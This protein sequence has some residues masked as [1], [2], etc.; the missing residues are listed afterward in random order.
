M[1]PAGARATFAIEGARAPSIESLHSVEVRSYDEHEHAALAVTR[2]RDD[3]AGDGAEIID[4]VQLPSGARPHPRAELEYEEV[5][6]AR[7]LHCPSYT[8]CLEFAANVRWRGF[9]CRRCPR[10]KSHEAMSPIA[11]GQ[12]TLAAII[13]LRR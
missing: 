3:D 5:E 2:A 7:K 9:H 1:T 8:E 6:D 10:F 4:L 13:R 11:E 12:G